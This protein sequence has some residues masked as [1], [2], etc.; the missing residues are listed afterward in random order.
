MNINNEILFTA[1]IS[2]KSNKKPYYS[3]LYGNRIVWE[4]N[5]LLELSDDLD[6]F[7]RTLDEDCWRWKLEEDCSFSVKSM[8]SKLDRRALG[9]EVRPEGETR[10]FLQI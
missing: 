6:G 7:V 4:N 10:V 2:T 3:S 9:K 5:L 8:Y 1:T